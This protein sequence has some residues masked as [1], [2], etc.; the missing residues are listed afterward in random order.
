M[1]FMPIIPTPWKEEIGG[2]WFKASTGNKLEN[3]VS[4]NQPFRA[5]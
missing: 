3:P 2:S 1:S 4:R 5:G